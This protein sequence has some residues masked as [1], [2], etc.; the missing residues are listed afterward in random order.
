MQTRKEQKPLNSSRFLCCGFALA[1]LI[2]TVLLSLPVSSSSGRG[3][4]LMNALFTSTSSVCVTGLSVIS[5]AADLSLFGQIIQLLLIQVG[6]LGFMVFGTLLFMLVGRKI[7][8]RNRLLLSESMNTTRLSGLLR[9][10]YWVFGLTL[11]IEL[12]GAA[13]LSIR[14][15]PEFGPARGLFMS[16]FHAVSA[17]C[18]AGFDLFGDSLLSRAN[19]PLIVLTTALMIIL[20]GL[21]FTLMVDIINNRRFSRFTVHTRLVLT[22]T[23]LLIVSGWLITL[24]TEW[25]NPGTLGSLP[26]AS[27]FMNA[28]FQSITLRTAGFASISQKALRPATKVISMIFM[29]IGAAPASTGGGVKLTT[30]SVLCLMVTANAKGRDQALVFGHTVPK[31]TV[32]RAMSL[33]LI[34][35]AV[36]LMDT[37]LLSL[38]EYRLDFIDV[39]FEAVSAFGTVGLSCDLTGQLSLAGRIVVIITMFIG[40]VGPLTLTLAIA[41]RQNRNAEKI[42]YPEAGIMIG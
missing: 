23:G 42:R 40:R 36:V 8:L 37:V 2:G 20:G 34:A 39:M 22:V 10:I 28:L 17:F 1:I 19:D 25:S 30:F 15:V 14:L 26:P 11:A 16:L 29:F 3:I 18:N 31:G 21:G 38:I 32:Q 9:L 27:R 6:G 7:T 13:L 5:S 12:C 33:F 41:R 35:F 4:G 24:A